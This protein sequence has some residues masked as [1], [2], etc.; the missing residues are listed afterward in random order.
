LKCGDKIPFN[1][2]KEECHEKIANSMYLY[3]IY[4]SKRSKNVGILAR[5]K[6]KNTK[7]NED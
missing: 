5:M 6:V 7:K 3:F 4:L 2:V 1:E